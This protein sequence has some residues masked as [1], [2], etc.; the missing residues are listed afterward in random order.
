MNRQ[1][2]KPRTR[3]RT[4]S[5]LAVDGALPQQ[6]RVLRRHHT[7]AWSTLAVLLLTIVGGTVLL[8]LQRSS[9]FIVRQVTV[10]GTRTLDPTSIAQKSGALGA[11]IY[12]VDASSIQ[13][14]ID[15]IPAV[16]SARVRRVWPN[17]ITI[18]VQ[19]R[20]PWGTWQLGGVNYLVDAH[21]V[22]LDVLG[23]PQGPTIYDLD[24]SPGLQ[25]GDRV[26]ADA[27]HLADQLAS[28]LPG[29]VSQQAS[30]FQYAA[31]GGLEVITDRGV[32]ARF[33]DS[34]GLDYKLSV[35]QAVDAKVGIS[36]VHLIDLRFQ[37]HPYFR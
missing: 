27:I 25:P 7:V 11:E 10:T 22:V 24:A 33:G 35:W 32:Q 34:Q 17:A 30:K 5:G 26:D 23:S 18:A 6:P 8:R 20:Q 12:T 4:R 13:N 2:N 16:E 29:A 37:N 36:H 21:G 15:T 14:T 31:D 9:Y 3:R 1:T 19:E 28:T